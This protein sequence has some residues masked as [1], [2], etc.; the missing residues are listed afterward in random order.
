MNQQ[1]DNFM[2]CQFKKININIKLS[3]GIGFRKKL[4]LSN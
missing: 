1:G 3:K 2:G 4:S